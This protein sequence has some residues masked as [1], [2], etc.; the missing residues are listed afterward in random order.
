MAADIS[1]VLPCYNEAA[2]LETLIDGY[3]RCLKDRKNCELVLVDNGS[4]DGTWELMEKL[5]AGIPSVPI[6]LV[7]V[8]ENKGY[9]Y[10]LVQGLKAAS[11]TFLSWS[12][13]DLQCP[14]DDVFR[15]YDAV[16]ACEDPEMTFGK[17]HRTNDRGS[18]SILTRIQTILARVVLGYKMVE[19]SAQP[20]LFHRS[21]FDLWQSPPRGYELDMYAYYHA[22]RRG[23]EIVSIDV[24]FLDRQEGESKWAYSI[25]SRLA[26]IFRNTLALFQLRFSR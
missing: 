20:K 2:S 8:P 13:A 14:P 26:T 4:T 7:R 6:L 9:G 5:K 3:L 18:A 19:I 11:G 22:L 16:G 21:F 15:L 17:G 1:I 12:H 10:G 25:K 24:V 23:M